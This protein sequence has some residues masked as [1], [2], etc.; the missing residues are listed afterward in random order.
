M[1]FS[2]SLNILAFAAAVA[3]GTIAVGTTA[4][5]AS[6]EPQCLSNQ[7]VWQVHRRLDGAIDQLQHDDRDY[8]G[9]R[10]AAVDDLSKARQQLVAAEQYAVRH[11]N[12]DPA[13]F[14]AFGAP[15][16]SDVPWGL[17]SQGASNGDMWHVR[18][19]VDGLVA[20]LNSDDR[21]YGGHKGDAIRDLQA[22]RN[23]M[24]AAER[25]ASTRG[26]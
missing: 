21:D 20:Q 18:A 22:A 26:F 16:G 25:Y 5:P 14:R 10:D 8:G 9:H 17:R 1:H 23:Q 15:G 12:D 2:R 24:L 13:C 7:N 4:A 3:A 6:A 11:D 19:W